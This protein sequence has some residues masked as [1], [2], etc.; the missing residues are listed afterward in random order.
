[1]LVTTAS[2]TFSLVSFSLTLNIF[3]LVRLVQASRELLLFRVVPGD[4]SRYLTHSNSDFGEAPTLP[5]RQHA[6]SHHDSS[7]SWS[8]QLG[9]HTP[10]RTIFLNLTYASRDERQTYQQNITASRLVAQYNTSHSS[11]SLIFRDGALKSAMIQA[12]IL[13]MQKMIES[14]DIG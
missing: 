12:T 1:M 3:Q 8:K 6:P 5:E 4:F 7:Q 2:L 11:H 9:D 14:L 10:A 13:S